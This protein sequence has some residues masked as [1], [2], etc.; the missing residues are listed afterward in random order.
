MIFFQAVLVLKSP[1]C[2]ATKY[3][4]KCING[5]FLLLFTLFFAHCDFP[6]S[7]IGGRLIEQEERGIQSDKIKLQK[8][9]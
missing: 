2:D 1:I 5:Y 4:L 9:Y 6:L 3:L 8:K 7:N